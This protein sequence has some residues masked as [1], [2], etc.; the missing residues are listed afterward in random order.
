MSNYWGYHLILD[1]AS[2]DVIDEV[3]KYFSPKKIR[4]NFLTRQAG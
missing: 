2:C 3:N 1:C 4:V